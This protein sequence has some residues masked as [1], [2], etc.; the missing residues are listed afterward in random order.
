MSPDS[1]LLQPDDISDLAEEFRALGFSVGVGECIR[2][3]QLMLSLAAE[4]GQGLAPP[5]LAT[6][7]APIFCTTPQ[8][9]ESFYKH[10]GRWIASKTHPSDT[11]KSGWK[12]ENLEQGSRKPQPIGAQAW[13]WI[14][15]GCAV[16]VLLLAGLLALT[17]WKS[18]VPRI[19][20][21]TVFDVN[22]MPYKGA[23][24]YLKDQA[25]VSKADG[26]FAI[27]IRKFDLPQELV[28]TTR[29]NATVAQEIHLNVNSKNYTQSQRI[30]FVDGREPGRKNNEVITVV[31][32]LS[33]SSLLQF[34]LQFFL[35]FFDWI[36][37]AL[38]LTPVLAFLGW[39][40]WIYLP[41]LQF[42]RRSSR[43]IFRTEKLFVKKLGP[44]IFANSGFRRIAQSLRRH[45][46]VGSLDLD[47]ERTVKESVSRGGWF[48][49]VYSLRYKLPEYLVLIDRAGYHDLQSRMIDELVEY[50]ENEKVIVNR[51]YFCE[52]P[53]F[54]YNEQPHSQPILLQDLAAKFASHSLIV[55][56]DAA[57]MFSPLTGRVYNWLELFSA[58]PERAVLLPGNS[59]R[60][61]SV[62]SVHYR[63]LEDSGF[64]VLPATPDGL[65]LLAERFVTQVA[66]RSSESS[67][68][69]RYP[70]LLN[71]QPL[72]W[73]DRLS[74]A[75][76]LVSRLLAQLRI[77]LGPKSFY[78]LCACA[79]YP[80][81]SWELT[82]YLGDRVG[83]LVMDK[84]ALTR[85]L[86]LPWFRYGTMPDWLRE[87]LITALPVDIQKRARNA[88]KLLLLTALV[89]KPESGMA[90]EIGG[91]VTDSHPIKGVKD[92]ILKNFMRTESSESL[93]RDYVLISFLYGPKLR[94]RAVAVPSELTRLLRS[95][96]QPNR[97]FLQAIVAIVSTVFIA[98][99]LRAVP[100]PGPTE[101][102]V[103]P[104][105]LSN[106]QTE[107]P[108]IGSTS[109]LQMELPATGSTSELQMELPA[110][111]STS[112]NQIKSDINKKSTNTVPE[113]PPTPSEGSPKT[114]QEQDQT[115]TSMP[116]PPSSGTKSD[117]ILSDN[118]SPADGTDKL[119]NTNAV[120][121]A[122]SP[123]VQ[124]KT[125]FQ[126]RQPEINLSA[127]YSSVFNYGFS[128]LEIDKGLTGNEVLIQSISISL[129]IK[130]RFGYVCCDAWVLL[131]P[132]PFGF[133]E[134]A[135]SGGRNP[136][137][138]QPS[139][140]VAPVQVHFV[141]GN[142]GHILPEGTETTLNAAYNFD[143]KQLSGDVDRLPGVFSSPLSL[144]RGLYAQIFLW[145]GN[146]TV[147]VDAEEI[148]LIVEGVKPIT[149]GQ[150]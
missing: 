3:Q 139:T 63:L 51:Y 117:Q 89:E 4:G 11:I 8:E 39:L 10:Y 1:S 96:A 33:P 91:N 37:A 110:T 2:S 147:N 138:I 142:N 23:K 15:L 58:W 120:T 90:L 16:G 29:P 42:V 107:V 114:P 149:A 22:G 134:G 66:D 125:V 61:V 21:G 112:V 20:T 106:I 17:L 92:V 88:L 127:Q 103:A 60:S 46:Q 45:R 50:L 69:G 131:G 19:L 105:S 100:R 81:L 35:H 62:S 93:L 38:I 5:E 36:C 104:T 121:Q 57:G 72:R 7:L 123:S 52:D 13:K 111:G 18:F 43:K 141:L 28:V 113:K 150:K 68:A 102:L 6:F 101:P 82:L 9:Q 56:S 126:F 54:C 48:T 55:F 65:S 145:N 79:V 122:P 76:S 30:T 144:P 86:R 83:G 41:R 119:T 71:E 98:Y 109:K 128:S 73:I 135:I 129:K 31:P 40:L 80:Q 25:T 146:P 116:P 137:Y 27:R 140:N 115:V 130:T 87:R 94:P 49:P 53:R 67:G 26:K 78:W 47:A 74:P 85:L 143:N 132:K 24:V 59:H 97:P 108:A 64:L 70:E 34:V 84:S 95:Y 14:G 32:P 12:S 148:S 75:Q 77:Y 133:S 44:G 124:F 118:R 99:A 136:Y